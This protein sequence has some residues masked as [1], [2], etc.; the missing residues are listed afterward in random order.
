MSTLTKKSGAS[1]GVI[2][3]YFLSKEDIIHTAAATAARVSSSLS[4]V[5]CPITFLSLNWLRDVLI[6][7]VDDRFKRVRPPRGGEFSTF[8]L[9]IP[10][11][12]S[13]PS[14]VGA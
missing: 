6:G 2:H 3:Y 8:N 12:L 5:A 4:R 9:P 7:G 1:A 14:M 13:A 11:S 10:L